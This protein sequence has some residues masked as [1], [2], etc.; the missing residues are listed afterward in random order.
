[1]LTK[2]TDAAAQN[3]W[4]CPPL[5]WHEFLPPEQEQA[6]L[7]HPPHRYPL[8]CKCQPPWPCSSQHSKGDHCGGRVPYSTTREPHGGDCI[9]GQEN[10]SK[11]A[12]KMQ[13][14]G[15]SGLGNEWRKRG[16]TRQGIGNQLSKLCRLLDNFSARSLSAF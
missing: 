13:G 2:Y 1:M 10:N 8:F 15:E 5:H 7:D 16:N 14:K 11:G 12:E 3:E 6:W 9:Q 4:A